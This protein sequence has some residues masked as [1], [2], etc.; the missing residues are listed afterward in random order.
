MGPQN[1]YGPFAQQKYLLVVLGFE[2]LIFQPVVPL[3]LNLGTRGK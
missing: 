1:R 3:N 2:T